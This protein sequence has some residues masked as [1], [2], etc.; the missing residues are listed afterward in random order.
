MKQF[1]YFRSKYMAIK[2][3]LKI[4][5][6][7]ETLSNANLYVDCDKERNKIQQNNLIIHKI[8]CYFSI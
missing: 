4:V 6:S 1:L 5:L 3:F 7:K 2:C 8:L